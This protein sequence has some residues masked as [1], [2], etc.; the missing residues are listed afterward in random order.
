[1]CKINRNFEVFHPVDFLAVLSQ[2]IPD[3]SVPMIRYYGL[4]SNK[5][6]GCAR[7]GTGHSHAGGHL[8]SQITDLKSLPPGSPPPP[9]KLPS[10]KWRDL[11]R[12][13]W[14][15]DPL[16]CPVYQKQMRVIAFID[17]PDV[18]EKILRHL[19]R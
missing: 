16:Q 19:N 14:H 11:I 15:T 8:K 2:H 18:V 17:D 9:R 1:V 5:M 4:C 7:T 12:Q 6:R 3:K 13:A 10:R